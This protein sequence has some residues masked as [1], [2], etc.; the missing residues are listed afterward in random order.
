M[1]LAWEGIGVE[2][3]RGG[4]KGTPGLTLQKEKEKANFSNFELWE[5][6][7]EKKRKK[8]KK[9]RLNAEGER[10]ED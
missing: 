8:K 2:R 3:K 5:G 1:L 4:G 10:K 7:T 9:A 6:G